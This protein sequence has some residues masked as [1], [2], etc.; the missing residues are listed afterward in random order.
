MFGARAK[1]RENRPQRGAASQRLGLALAASAL[2]TVAVSLPMAYQAHEARQ[3]E[4]RPSGPQVE[5]L[6]ASSVPE[7]TPRTDTLFWQQG[8]GVP[9][10]LDQAEVPRS[11]Q[12]LLVD[13][14]EVV[15]ADFCLDD[16]AVETIRGGPYEI[17]ADTAAALTPG[18]H[19]LTVTVTYADDTVELHRVSFITLS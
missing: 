18:E 11:A 12:L 10:L 6:G 7:T 5:V 2:L 3:Q 8:A 1:Q 15:R 17:S 16:G 9:Q 4:G 19:T 14:E 13:E